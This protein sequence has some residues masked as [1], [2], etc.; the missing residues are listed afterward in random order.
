[1]PNLFDYS[2]F[3]L[4]ESKRL[5]FREPVQTDAEAMLDLFGNANVTRYTEQETLHHIEEAQ[6]LIHFFRRGFVDG[7][8]VRW[9]MT[10]K[11]D[12]QAIGTF[13][14]HNWERNQYRAEIGYD[15]NEKHWN[16]GITTE[17]VTRMIR[18]GIEQMQLHRVEAVL[19]PDNHASAR[20]LEKVG[21]QREG[22]ARKRLF[23]KG[24]F[25]D[26]AQYAILKQ[27]V[28]GE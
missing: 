16:Q 3:P 27:D 13:S 6:W 9:V 21:F 15:L 22:I 14:Y 12:N 11:D 8:R 4:L 10:L 25:Y 5:R 28:R 26:L 17:A 24:K 20:V 7:I 23:M 19:L 18:F 1:M 2:E